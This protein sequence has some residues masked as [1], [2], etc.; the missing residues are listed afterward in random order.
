MGGFLLL[1]VVVLVAMLQFHQLQ[2]QQSYVNNT[3][4]DCDYNYNNTLG[5]VCNGAASSCPSYL[6]FRSN[7]PYNTPLLIGLLLNANA[8]EIARLNNIPRFA[9]IPSGTLLVVPINC[10]CT[11]TTISRFYQHNASYILNTSDTYFTVANNSYQGLTT[12]QSLKAQNPF[13]YRHLL[14]GQTLKIPLRCACPTSNQTAAGI[15]Y[16]LTYLVVWTNSVEL[17]GQAFGGVDVQSINDANEL[18]SK[19]LIFPSPHS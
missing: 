5:Y 13:N 9:T 1:I 16:L 6:T 11:T 17:I 19:D 8:S 15:K 10:S 3:Q 2:G 4:L 14:P 18:T 7:P 12:C